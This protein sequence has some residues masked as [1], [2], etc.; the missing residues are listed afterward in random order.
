MNDKSLS[1]IS[2]INFKN[3]SESEIKYILKTES[4]KFGNLNMIDRSIE[5]VEKNHLENIF[6]NRDSDITKNNYCSN[7]KSKEKNNENS[8][9]NFLM[10]QIIPFSEKSP[11][12]KTFDMKIRRTRKSGIFSFDEFKEDLANRLTINK[13]RNRAISKKTNQNKNEMENGISNINKNNIFN[14]ENFDNTQF[15]ITKPHTKNSSMKEIKGISIKKL[16]SDLLDKNITVLIMSLATIYALI[17]CDFNVIF[18]DNDVDVIFSILSG[19]VFTLFLLE[20]ILSVITKKDYNFNFFFWFDLF[21]IFSMVI[22]IDWIIFPF[23]GFISDLT[24]NESSF[25]NNKAELQKLMENI[26]EVVRHTRFLNNFNILFKI[27]KNL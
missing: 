17:F 20:F 8:N 10:N 23:L 16:I 13:T 5:K 24:L 22:N 26:S 21:S 6:K 15:S 25:T 18:F 12:T 7:D 9:N 1:K 11:K 4:N 3:Q 2:Q 14:N 27:L 19:I